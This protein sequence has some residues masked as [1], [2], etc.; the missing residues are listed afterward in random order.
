MEGPLFDDWYFRV[1]VGPPLYAGDGPRL[2]VAWQ[3]P[4]R[5]QIRQIRIRKGLDPVDLA[6][7]I[8]SLFAGYLVTRAS[9]VRRVLASM[10]RSGASILS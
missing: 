4:E 3:E 10:E 5:D 1:S 6:E 2:V 8:G 7:W 9:G